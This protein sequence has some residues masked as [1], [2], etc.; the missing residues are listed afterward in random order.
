VDNA[1]GAFQKAEENIFDL[2]FLDVEM[3]GSNGLALCSRIRALANHKNTPILFV[4]AHSDLKTRASSKIS[5]ANHFLLKPVNTH[6]LAVTAWTYLFKN[7][8]KSASA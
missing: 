6:E 3:P 1:E 4:T 7:R 2:M 5:G 8:L